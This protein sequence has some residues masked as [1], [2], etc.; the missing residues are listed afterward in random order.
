MNRKLI[1]SIQQCNDLISKMREDCIV[2]ANKFF[3]S[4]ASVLQSIR[5]DELDRVIE[6]CKQLNIILQEEM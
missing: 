3:G 5:Q 1:D 6:T 4:T 2:P